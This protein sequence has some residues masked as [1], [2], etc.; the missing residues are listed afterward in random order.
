MAGVASCVKVILG[1]LCL[2][3]MLIGS[4]AIGFCSWIIASGGETDITALDQS[5]F[6][7]A[8]CLGSVVF[9]VGFFGCCGVLNENGCLLKMFTFLNVLALLGELGLG[10]LIIYYRLDIDNYKAKTWAGAGDAVRIHIQGKLDCCAYNHPP[11]AQE[12]TFKSFQDPSCY[13]SGFV[14]STQL[15][16]ECYPLIDDW[17][18]SSM[19]GLIVG[20]SLLFCFQVMAV[21]YGCMTISWLSRRRREVGISEKKKRLSQRKSQPAW[22]NRVVPVEL[23]DMSNGEYR[24]RQAARNGF[25]SNQMLVEDYDNNSSNS[26]ESD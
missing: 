15:K 22:N 18:H 25:V 19:A 2:T 12:Q 17:L 16:R 26:Y 8:V 11:S 7:V 20:G 13:I 24:Q 21:V 10:V 23:T 5:L 14:N 4:V 1:L 3:F 9:I 6:I